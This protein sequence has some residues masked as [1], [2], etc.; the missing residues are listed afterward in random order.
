VGVP[1]SQRKLDG[2]SRHHR[3]FPARLRCRGSHPFD[4]TRASGAESLVLR[5]PMPLRSTLNNVLPECGQFLESARP[6]VNVYRKSRLRF[7]PPKPR[8]SGYFVVK[9][10]CIGQLEGCR[11]IPSLER[12]QSRE[13]ASRDS[14]FLRGSAKRQ[15]IPKHVR[16]CQAFFPRA[17]PRGWIYECAGP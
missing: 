9:L 7:Y 16:K 6:A 12:F 4:R 10:R 3:L 8:S 1:S 14:R 17:S 5:S 15:I 2:R 11:S 13:N